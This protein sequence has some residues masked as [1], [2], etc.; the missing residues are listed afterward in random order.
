[1]HKHCILVH[2]HY[3]TDFALC[4]CCRDLLVP[5]VRRELL[6]TREREA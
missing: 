5:V 4:V 2:P 6:E 1:M 3:V